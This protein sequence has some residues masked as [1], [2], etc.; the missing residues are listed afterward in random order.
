[1]F[2]LTGIPPSTRGIPQ[3]EVTFDIDAN[4]ILNVTAKDLATGRENKIMITASTKLSEE[5]KNRLIKAAEQFSEQDRMK[6][7]EAE[8]R[9]NADALI[10]TAEKTKADLA[11]KISKENVERID[12]AASELRAA[13]SNKDAGAIKA[14]TDVLSKTLQEIGTAAYQE[15]AQR[16]QQQEQQTSEAGE[17]PKAEEDKVVD[18]D[19]RVVDEEKK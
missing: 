11:G 6:K 4:G 10:Y 3:I 8:A 5:E 13:L 14:K 1:M 17:P 15:A 7:E 16:S 18:A 9:N 12:Q 19:Y 2:N